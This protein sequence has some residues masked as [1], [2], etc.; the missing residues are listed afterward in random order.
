MGLGNIRQPGIKE[1]GSLRR[2]EQILRLLSQI[3]LS[4]KTILDVACGPGLNTSRIAH[5]AK[6][7]IGI[8][9]Q[10][11]LLRQARRNAV[12]LGAGSEFVYARAERLPFCDLSVDV[13][14]IMEAL[15]HMQSHDRVLQEAYRVLKDK[16]YLV[17]S[18]PNKLYPLEIHYI[19]IGKIIFK[20]FY[21]QIP[22]FSWAPS[23]VRKKFATA[24]VYTGKEITQA[25]EANGFAACEIQ[26]GIF[27]RLDNLGSRRI[28]KILD[29]LFTFLENN[30]FLNRFGMSIFVL[31]QKK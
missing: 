7:A 26:Y 20:G 13:V 23:S 9:M 28:T 11:S 14:L 21:G 27:P 12:A 1:L 30:R 6:R 4:D 24:K 17:V 8:D 19:R 5:L 18:V 31:A 29:T 22:F 2:T 15:E 3:S 16:S 10:G 25:I